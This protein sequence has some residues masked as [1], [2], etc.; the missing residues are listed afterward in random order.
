M[1]PPTCGPS[2]LPLLRLARVDD[3]ADEEGDVKE[4]LTPLHLVVGRP[5]HRALVPFDHP[6]G[7]ATRPH[8][9]SGKNN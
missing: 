8:E 7:I 1:P 5:N 3:W 2:R 9:R 6:F 4:T